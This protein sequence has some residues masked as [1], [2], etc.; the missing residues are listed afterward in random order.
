[1]NPEPIPVLIVDDDPVF[2]RFVRQLVE[3]LG[4]ELRCAPTWVDSAEKAFKAIERDHYELALLDY[5]MP[6][7]SGLDLLK[8]IQRLP[9]PE[10]PAVI[11][12]TASGNEAVAVE[13]MKS[14]AKDYLT[15]ADIDVP[16]LMRAIKNALSQKRLAEQVAAYNAQV[17]ADLEMARKLQESLLPQRY[18]SF[19]RTATPARSALRFY[20][21]YFWTTRL[22]G[23][24]FNVQDLSDTKAGVLI[25]DVMGHG[26]RA[27]LVT[28]M[29]RALVG[30]LAA[31]AGNPGTFL[32]EMNH[33]LT[34]ILKQIGEP[35]YA[36]AF[37]LIAD[38]EAGHLRYASAGQPRPLHVQRR[39]GVV[40]PLRVPTS[41]GAALGLFADARYL[42]CECELAPEDLVLLFTDGLIEVTGNQ[43]E[44]Y[45]QERLLAAARQRIQLPL[46]RLVDELIEDARRFSGDHEFSDDVCL[47]GMEAAG[48]R[49]DAHTT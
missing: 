1:M 41:A 42:T 46:A 36:T 10:Q 30:D 13:A 34:A 31:E 27:A 5:H 9:L 39:A 40:A 8:G 7:A 38:I 12:L 35:L 22:G 3:S 43:D 4:D 48:G 29:L 49:V 28:A 15:K 6:G 47:L 23:D 26:V 45:G 11:M 20:H 21:R 17:N 33:R 44:E 24:F 37:Y 32:A 16:P 14:G 25:C 19:P 18:P 2:S